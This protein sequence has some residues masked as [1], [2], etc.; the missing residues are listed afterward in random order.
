MEIVFDHDDDTSELESLVEQFVAAL[1]PV[2]GEKLLLFRDDC[3]GAI[4]TECHLAADT[5][6]KYS[7][8]DVPLDPDASGEYRAN[9]Q[10]V[11]DHAAFKQMEADALKGRSFSNFVC[12]FVPG[13]LRPLEII[14]GQHRYNAV[15]GALEAGISNRSLS[16]NKTSRARCW[17]FWV[18]RM[19]F[20]RSFLARAC[21]TPAS[22]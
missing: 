18:A 6:L 2:E 5:M 11:D 7:T 10:L 22:D 9:R 1:D 15:K 14:G 17:R 4:F 12:E 19:T 3:T 21:P 8:D 13:K 16:M 20:L